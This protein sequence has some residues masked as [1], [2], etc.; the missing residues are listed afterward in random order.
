MCG[1]PSSLAFLLQ[2]AQF[3]PVQVFLYLCKLALRPMVEDLKNVT[4]FL[5]FSK[6]CFTWASFHSFNTLLSIVWSRQP[7]LFHPLTMLAPLSATFLKRPSSSPT[8]NYTPLHHF[9]MRDGNF[10]SEKQ[11]SIVQFFFEF[12][13]LHTVTGGPTGAHIIRE[14]GLSLCVWGPSIQSNPSCI[15]QFSNLI[16]YHR[17]TLQ[18]QQSVDSHDGLINC[19]LISKSSLSTV[20]RW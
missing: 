18:Y 3:V 14:T 10:F 8:F 17:Q 13:S 9:W 7:K 19:W 1:R 2:H 20:V 5:P 16:N 11:K 15:C 12:S 6:D 4:T